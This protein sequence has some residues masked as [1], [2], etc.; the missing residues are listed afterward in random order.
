MVKPFTERLMSPRLTPGAG[1]AGIAYRSSVLPRRALIGVPGMHV[2]AARIVD[3][4]ATERR[5]T[6][7]G[8]SGARSAGSFDRARSGED[9][10]RRGRRRPSRILTR[11]DTVDG[12]DGVTRP[13]NPPDDRLPTR[14][15]N[16]GQRRPTRPTLVAFD[17]RNGLFGCRLLV[18]PARR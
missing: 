13:P 4:V 6:S 15:Q 16:L 12:C 5:F 1:P 18:D 10:R 2:D 11:G 7:L 17:W 3:D 8:R 14:G 9:S